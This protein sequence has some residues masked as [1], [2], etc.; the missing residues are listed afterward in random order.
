VCSKDFRCGVRLS[1]TG[2]LIAALIAGGMDAAEAAG[3][4]A[5]AGVEMTGALTK[6]SSNAARQQR[7]RDRNASVTKRN[8]NVTETEATERNETV[9]NRNETVTRNVPSLS[10]EDKK[11][12]NK[13]E[14]R[15]S[16]L[17]EGWKPDDT[18][19]CEAIAKLGSLERAERELRKFT[20]H[21][22]AKG[23]VAKNWSA[24]WD[25][26]V[27][28]A[29]EWGNGNGNSDHRTNPAAGRATARE[30][31]HVATM[32]G[33]ALRY[34]QEGKSAGTRRDLPDDADAAGGPDAVKGAKNAH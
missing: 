8:E 15:A 19:W 21:A 4:V 23:R 26:W 25:N 27:D 29:L 3:L 18:R 17:P 14:R 16:Q 10:K 22:L 24:A 32:G 2:D 30:A 20:N 9:T 31:Q 13:R 28:R 5:R 12:N 6:K 7:Y 34:L 33:A 11:E 1:A